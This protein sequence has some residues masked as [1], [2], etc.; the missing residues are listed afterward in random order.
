[1]QWLALLVRRHTGDG[2]ARRVIALLRPHTRK[3]LLLLAAAGVSAALTTVPALAYQMI[4][5][6]GIG[7]GDLGA[8]IAFSL[9]ALVAVTASAATQWGS[10]LL[11]AVLSNH[12]GHQLR[13]RIFRHVQRLDRGFHVTRPSG[14]VLSRMNNDVQAAQGIVS[15]LIVSILSNIIKLVLVIGAMTYFSWQLVGLALVG[16]V[17]AIPITRHTARVVQQVG[18]R[19]Q[20]SLAVVN[21]FL[22]DRLNVDGVMVAALHQGCDRD[23]LAFDALADRV[24]RDSIRTASISS[25]FQTALTCVT[26]LSVALVYLVG[27]VLVV[28][29]Q[30]TLGMLVGF[31][32][33]LP[34]VHGP[35]TNIVNARVE[36]VGAMVSFRRIFEILDVAP[37]ITAHPDAQPLPATPSRLSF[38]DVGFM[39]PSADRVDDGQTWQLRD[40]SFA[41][42][43]G[44]VTALLGPSGAGKSTIAHLCAR[45]RDPVTGRVRLDDRPLDELPLADVT[46]HIGLLSQD[47]YMFHQSISE[48]LRYARPDATEAEMVDALQAAEL[49][50]ELI[51]QLPDG[52]DTV[53]GD[54]GSRL[55]GGERQR[56]AI[57]RLLLR[58]PAFIV[59][60]EATASLDE[61]TARTVLATTLRVFRDCGILVITHDTSIAAVADEL[62]FLADGR[63]SSVKPLSVDQQQIGPL[64]R[65]DHPVG[66]R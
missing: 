6:A 18:E 23:G 2:A 57:A 53:V 59:L 30:M 31:V 34:S 12:L 49:W 63:L 61:M 62:I 51:S 45:L 41:L 21:N 36:V 54:R 50:S 22:V 64:L 65:P 44:K 60:D 11:S 14:D 43:R 3:I 19:R 29:Q 9:L 4:I 17:L 32:A 26:G 46:R 25:G 16:P 10:Q 48:N 28:Q 27:G 15:N 58:R 1:M 39:H 38:T 35:L 56:L 20:K 55:S 8:L 33:L 47:S 42:D 13:T 40:I 7:Q 52:L 5:D 37:A 24:R 66:A